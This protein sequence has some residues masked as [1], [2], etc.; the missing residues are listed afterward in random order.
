MDFCG[1]LS[2]VLVRSDLKRKTAGHGISVAGGMSTLFHWQLLC[3]R[4][5]AEWI[6]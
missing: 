6:L 1:L 4:R 2:S 3:L 5:I